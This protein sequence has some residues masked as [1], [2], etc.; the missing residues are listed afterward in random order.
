LTRELVAVARE[1]IAGSERLADGLTDA[2][3][4]IAV[5]RGRTVEWRDEI[6]FWVHVAATAITLIGLWG[7]LGQ[8]CLIGWGRRRFD[9]RATRG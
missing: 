5:V 2:R 7:G 8:L 9:R 6:V 1:A 3:Q 4:A